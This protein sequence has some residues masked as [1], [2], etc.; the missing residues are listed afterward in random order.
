MIITIDILMKHKYIQMEY[1]LYGQ[2]VFY[3][4]TVLSLCL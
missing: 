4:P 3:E 1:E 2:N